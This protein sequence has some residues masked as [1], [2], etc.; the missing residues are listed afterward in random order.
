MEILL[1]TKSSAP[2][3]GWVADILGY[4]M[5]IIFQVTARFGIVNIGWSIII[6]TVIMNLILLPLTIKQQKSSK[7]MTVMQPEI[8][9]IQKKY[10]GKTDQDSMLKQQNEMKA[11][12]EKYGTSMTGGCVQLAIQMPILLA[13][14]QVIIKIPAYV[15]SVRLVFENIA[16]PLMQEPNWTS[17]VADIATSLRMP[18]DK[19]D[20]TDIGRVI[21]LLYKFTPANWEKL[22]EIF[23]NLITVLNE[24]VPH[25]ESMNM[26]F[27]INLATAPWQGFDKINIAWIIPVLSGLTQW[28]STILM[29]KNQP[30][31]DDSPMGQ[32]MKSMNSVMP[33][34]SVWFCFTLPAGLGL[35]WIASAAARILQQLA[36]NKYLEKID[37]E[38]MVEDNLKKSNEKRAKKGLAPQ[39]IDKNAIEKAKREEE[40]KE[41]EEVLEEEKKE[42]SKKHVEESTTYYSENANSGSLASRANMVAMF[43]KKN[44]RKK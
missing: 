28:Y 33:L 20:Y 23:P 6:F 30:N 40:R 38:K 24:N 32:N 36:I 13:L 25:I 34:M 14:Y 12:Y 31:N 17:K 3:I 39:R 18:I 44:N 43:D 16:N 10:K 2:V 11:V 8:Q 19:I 9:A 41:K 15:S 26:F 1:L 4:I 7:L 27:G 22:K 29:M 35:Y 42:K 37:I 5:N 21:D